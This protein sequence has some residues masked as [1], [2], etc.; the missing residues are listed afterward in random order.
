VS[1]IRPSMNDFMEADYDKRAKISD[2]KIG[3]EFRGP[4]GEVIKVQ[5]R[6]S[7]LHALLSSGYVEDER[8]ADFRA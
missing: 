5:R 8:A 4:D 2:K 1:E 6:D 7:L 3:P